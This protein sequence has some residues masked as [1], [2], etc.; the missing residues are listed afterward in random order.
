MIN[1]IEIKKYFYNY[2]E[3]VEYVFV[4]GVLALNNGVFAGSK[5]GMSLKKSNEILKE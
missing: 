5:S 2:S 4:N 3:C 1:K